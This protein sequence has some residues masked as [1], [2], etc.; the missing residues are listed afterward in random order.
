MDPGEGEEFDALY[1][2]ERKQRSEKEEESRRKRH[3]RESNGELKNVKRVDVESVRDVLRKRLRGEEIDKNSYHGDEG[4]RPTVSQ[5]I[6]ADD[7]TGCSRRQLQAVKGNSASWLF[8]SPKKRKKEWLQ[9]QLDLRRP[10]SN[11]SSTAESGTILRSVGRSGKSHQTARNIVEEDLRQRLQEMD[12]QLTPTE[13]ISDSSTASSNRSSD[14]KTLSSSSSSG[15]NG[16][17]RS[18]NH[19]LSSDQKMRHKQRHTN[20]LKYFDK[21]G[22]HRLSEKSQKM[23]GRNKSHHSKLREKVSNSSVKSIKNTSTTV[24]SQRRSVKE[25]QTKK[26]D[27]ESP[28]SQKISRKSKLRNKKMMNDKR[29]LR[30]KQLLKMSSE[31]ELRNKNRKK[32]KKQLNHH[33]LKRKVRNEQKMLLKSKK[34]TDKRLSGQTKSS[35]SDRS[36]NISTNRNG[37][38]RSRRKQLNQKPTRRSPLS[39]SPSQSSSTPSSHSK[40][41]KSAEGQYDDKNFARSQRTISTRKSAKNTTRAHRSGSSDEE[42][43][44]KIQNLGNLQKSAELST[45][46]STMRTSDGTV[47]LPISA[48]ASKP[49]SGKSKRC[50]E[51]TSINTSTNAVTAANNILSD[52]SRQMSDSQISGRKLNSSSFSKL[53]NKKSDGSSSQKLSRKQSK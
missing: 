18:S 33:R 40:V 27:S 13:T 38:G 53:K 48:A 11:D 4:S 25:R 23:E 31:E 3:K 26:Q 1:A 14:L 29:K 2:Q 8:K 16:L 10:R 30:K 7:Y 50:T 19:Q 32:L 35:L 42:E 41:K 17:A 45:A 44:E 46:T 49:T 9:Q 52:C 5:R 12:F 20:K 36:S 15:S 43:E 37:I 6:T 39:L 21:S 34:E 47:L 24:D 22:N 28:T 51:I